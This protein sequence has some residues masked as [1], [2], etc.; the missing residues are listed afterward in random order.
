MSDDTLLVS[1]VIPVC[2]VARYLDACVSSIV[3]QTYADLQ[4]VLVDDGSTD[5]SSE[6][7]DYW[8]RRDSRVEVVHQSNSGVS[9]ARNVGLSRVRGRYVMFVDGDDVLD[10]RGIGMLVS[11]AIAHHSQ[12]VF[13]SN[14]VDYLVDGT[15]VSQRRN[16][17]TPFEVSSSDAF[18]SRYVEL[19]RNEYVCPPWNKLFDMSLVTAVGA[20]FPEDVRYGEDLVFNMKLYAAAERVS[21]IDE[22]LYHYVVR[23][24]SA[25]SVFNPGWFA[26]RS[27]AY[28]LM[29]P[30]AQRW[31]DAVRNECDNQTVLEVDRV[32]NALYG[33]QSEMSD[34]DRIDY[35]RMIV[36][37]DVMQ[38][39]V[40][41]MKP[42][43]GRRA[44]VCRLLKWK[45]VSLLCLYGWLIAMI[46]KIGGRDR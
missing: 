40:S 2:N 31:G 29:R 46:K 39:C 27:R 32:I 24:T 23:S 30:I 25:Q 36:N 33:S 3:Q 26:N 18:L 9:A 45:S 21:L 14:S 7:C 8:A 13:F 38:T 11:H 12:I 4:I 34:K 41:Q 22:P 16:H 1:V 17:M 37:D 44:I 15:L 28:V 42:I 10:S 43:D 6:L 5:G 20:C 19:S 35:V